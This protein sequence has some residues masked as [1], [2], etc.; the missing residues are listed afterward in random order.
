MKANFSSVTLWIRLPSSGGLE[1]QCTYLAES[2]RP[3][4][5]SD[6]EWNGTGAGHLMTNSPTVPSSFLGMRQNIFPCFREIWNFDKSSSTELE[7]HKMHTSLLFSV[8]FFWLWNK[9]NMK[10]TSVL[11]ICHALQK[12]SLV[13]TLLILKTFILKTGPMAEEWYPALFLNLKK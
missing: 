6:R 7:K 10:L 4:S 2:S 8:L 12:E 1:L 3:T 13:F 5:H 11:K 9:K